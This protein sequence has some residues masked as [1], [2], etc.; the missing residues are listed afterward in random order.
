MKNRDDQNF[1]SYNLSKALLTISC[2]GHT[3]LQFTLDLSSICQTDF[4]FF[5]LNNTIGFL[6]KTFSVNIYHA[7]YGATLVQMGDNSLFYKNWKKYEVF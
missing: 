4:N 3:D 5:L 7:N 6:Q 1:S 2:S